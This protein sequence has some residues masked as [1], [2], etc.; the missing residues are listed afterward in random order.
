M[1]SGVADPPIARHTGRATAQSSAA[2]DRKAVRMASCIM[3]K[4]RERGRRNIADRQ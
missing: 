1:I 2:A 4:A 3:L